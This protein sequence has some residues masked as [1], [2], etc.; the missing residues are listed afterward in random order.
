MVPLGKSRK[1][2]ETAPPLRGGGMAASASPAHGVF[3]SANAAVFLALIA[4]VGVPGLARAAEAQQPKDVVD[5]VVRAMAHNYEQIKSAEVTIEVKS[6][7][8]RSVLP[9]YLLK[10]DPKPRQ[11]PN[12]LGVF[13]VAFRHTQHVII[14][15][16]DLRYELHRNDGISQTTVC[17]AGKV[18]D[19]VPATGQ[20]N[21][22]W[23]RD[24]RMPPMDPREVGTA[25]SSVAL[26]DFLRSKE[27]VDARLVKREASSTIARVVLKY[28]RAQVQY[29]FDSSLG[30]LPTLKVATNPDGSVIS[31]LQISYQDVLDGKARFVKEAVERFFPPGA[32]KTPTEK[33][34]HQR[35][36][37]TVT[38]LQIN[39]EI[40]D[41]AFQMDMAA[42]TRVYDWTKGKMPVEI[43]PPLGR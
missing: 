10:P 12:I 22:R 2:V 38:K 37:Y 42:D 5:M 14:R 3:L 8:D 25:D 19:Y 20:L 33:G 9:A 27:L 26:A 35:I 16:E 34:W 18:F 11:D 30:F 32:T 29:E 31:W 6:E 21:I 40:D 23:T 24:F 39:P 13:S 36:R 43:T 41:K 28:E 7:E 4:A 1:S 15:G 17:K